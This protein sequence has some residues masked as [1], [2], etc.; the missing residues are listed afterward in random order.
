M[1]FL[2]RSSCLI[3]ADVP[4]TMRNTFVKNYKAV[5]RGTN[6][7]VLFAG[8]QKIEHL[9][10]NFYGSG[11]DPADNNPEHLFEIA[12]KGYVGALAT[13]LGLIMRYGA[14][15]PRVNYIAKLNAKTNLVV[16]SVRDPRSLNLWTVADVVAVQQQS[17]LPI[18]GIGYTLY[19]GSEYEDVMLAQ[20][21]QSI[22]QAHQH[23][24]LAT[25]WIYPRG[26][27]VTDELDGALSTGL[28]GIANALGADFVK[29]NP[30]QA[31]DG[32]SSAEWLNIATQAAGNTK[33][34]CS[35]GKLADP[36]LFLRTLHEQLHSGNTAG[37]AIGRN[38][39]QRSLHEAV[40]FTKAVAAIVY[41]NRSVAEAVKIFAAV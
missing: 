39:H 9:N 28:G 2:K 16:A 7:F 25:L 26:V 36:E 29:I 40:A 24:L 38:I 18:C 31:T 1:F 8:D 17:G 10:Q 27:S 21:A 23:G 12:A 14:N 11:I 6:R 33:I 3:P 20:A 34:I 4:K 15:Y 5:T 37:S 13:N 22:M 41:E 30:P 32:K 19:P 35:G